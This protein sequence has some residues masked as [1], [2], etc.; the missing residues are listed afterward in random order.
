[1]D[2]GGTLDHIDRLIAH[3]K[4]LDHADRVLIT[5]IHK[6]KGLE[7][8][9]VVMPELK[10][11]KFPSERQPNIESERRIFYVGIYVG[12]TRAKKM[13]YLIGND[14]TEKVT[15]HWQSKAKK[16]P[17]KRTSSRFLYE[18]KHKEKE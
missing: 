9:C 12:M 10:E 14:D 5:S 15:K 8:D 4:S 7:F 3:S 17:Q 16:V 6:A 1:M 2:I 11:G 18:A 13:L